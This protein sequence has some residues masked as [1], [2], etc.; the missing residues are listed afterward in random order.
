MVSDLSLLCLVKQM[1]DELLN[2][3]S[4]FKVLDNDGTEKGVDD[5]V[6]D[7]IETRFKTKFREEVDKLNKAYTKI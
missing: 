2:L 3:L 5:S 7:K 1:K 4:M 6:Y